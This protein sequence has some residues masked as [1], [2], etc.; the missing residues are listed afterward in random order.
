MTVDSSREEV[1][2]ADEKVN[3]KRVIVVAVDETE[4]SQ[5]TVNFVINTIVEKEYGHDL[6][7]LL[8]VRKSVSEFFGLPSGIVGGKV[9]TDNCRRNCK[10]DQCRVSNKFLSDSFKVRKPILKE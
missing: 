2:K 10:K 3:P 4:S 8:N 6:V 7:V 9:I 5:D 1:I